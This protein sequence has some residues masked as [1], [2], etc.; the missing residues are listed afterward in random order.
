MDWTQVE[1]RIA[2]DDRRKWDRKA[3]AKA[4]KIAADGALELADRDGRPERFAL[5]ELATSQMCQRLGIPVL[6]Y[7][8][9]PDEIRATV[10]N[11]DFGRLKDNAYL[12][13]GKDEWVRAFLSTDYV[14]YNNAEIAE[15]VKELLK[16]ANATTKSFVLEETHLYLKVI[17]D[18]LVDRDSGLKAGVMIGNSEVG[19]GSVSVEPFVFRLACT[20][21]LVVSKE[22]SFRHPHTRLS[23][24][25]LRKGTALA[26]SI[27]FEVASSVLD[28]FLKTR[29]EPVPDPVETI[30]QLAE[31]RKLSRKFADEVVSSYAVEPE[32]TRF[33]VINAFTR[34]AQ[35]LGPLQQIE[36]ERFAGTLLDASP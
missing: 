9:L 13:R 29:E 10:A 32:P 22:Q 19:L 26:I 23:L 15:T 3:P 8:R 14:A 20:N 5:A 28:A 18:D 1:E 33:G 17:S 25:E 35:K 2:D 4:L 34:A 36:V 7:R 30:R 6:Y 21:D 31:A 16:G 12:L 24:D 11:Y 27:A